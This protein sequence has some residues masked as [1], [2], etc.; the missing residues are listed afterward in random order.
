[1][2]KTILALTI[3]TLSIGAYANTYDADK[4]NYAATTSQSDG[5]YHD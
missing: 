1:M 5:E 4:T 3:A 2:K